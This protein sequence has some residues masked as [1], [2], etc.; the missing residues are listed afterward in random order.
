MHNNN[1]RNDVALTSSYRTQRIHQELP[2]GPGLDML[3][4]KNSG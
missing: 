1:N 3:R 4:I 2:H